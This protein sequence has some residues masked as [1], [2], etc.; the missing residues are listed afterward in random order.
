[1]FLA[2]KEVN[3]ARHETLACPCYSVG[4][5]S[6]SERLVNP[7]LMVVLD[8]SFLRPQ[9]KINLAWPL[10]FENGLSVDSGCISAN[11]TKLSVILRSNLVS[12]SG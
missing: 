4:N 8:D 10:N 7:S 12:I 9:S 2:N 3:S 11:R 5:H 1:M 6:V